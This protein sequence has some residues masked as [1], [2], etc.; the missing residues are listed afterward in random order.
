M[1]GIYPKAL[2]HDDIGLWFRCMTCRGFVY[3]G[4]TVILIACYAAKTFM[5]GISSLSSKP[6]LCTLTPHRESAE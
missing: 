5:E 1:V 3:C 6:M 2:F 4:S